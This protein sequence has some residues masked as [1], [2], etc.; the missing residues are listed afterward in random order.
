[1]SRGDENRL[2]R[3]GPNFCAAGAIAPGALR[4]GQSAPAERSERTIALR[5]STT[6][7]RSTRSIA[8]YQSAPLGAE[9]SGGNGALR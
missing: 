1:M 9:R 6:V 8:L 5:Q 7:K 3:R 2:N 4:R